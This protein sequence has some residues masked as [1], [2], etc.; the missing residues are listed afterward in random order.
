MGFNVSALKKKWLIY[1]SAT[2]QVKVFAAE[3][4]E[5]NKYAEAVYE[6][7]VQTN[8]WDVGDFRRNT[9]YVT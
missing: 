8:S 2:L 5:V 6:H 7:Q 4:W 3:K 9:S 1:T